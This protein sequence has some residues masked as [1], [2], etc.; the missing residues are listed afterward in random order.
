MRPSMQVIFWVLGAIALLGCLGIML[1][2]ELALYLAFGWVAFLVNV[3]PQVQVAWGGVALAVI[4]LVAFAVGAHWFFGWLI[5]QIKPEN[6]WKVRWTASLVGVIVVMFVAGMATAGMVHQA[7]WLL[8][9]KQ[10][11]KNGGASEAARRSQSVNNLKQ[12]GLALHNYNSVFRSFPPGGTFDG[13]G[14]PQHSWMTSILPFIEQDA[15]YKRIDLSVPWDHPRNADAFR[16]RV[17]PYLRPGLP[18]NGEGYA[19]AQYAANSLALGGNLPRTFAS[20]TDGTVNTFIAGEVPANFKPWGD[21]TNWRDPSK[22][23]NQ[24]PD[25]FGGPSPRGANFLFADGSVRFLR[26]TIDP[27]V[28]KALGTPAANDVV[29]P[30]DY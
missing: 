23:I 16:T 4:C 15:L 24:S 25:G 10:W 28:F 6:R 26:N 2:F 22:G 19:P 11:L 13:R 8:S 14:Q 5:A 7:G 18:D 3:L 29:R 17:N 20:F 21:P 27:K 1:P 12:I 30:E 9:S